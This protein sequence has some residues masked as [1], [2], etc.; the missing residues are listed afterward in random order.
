MSLCKIKGTGRSLPP[1]IFYADAAVVLFTDESGR[2]AAGCYIRYPRFAAISAHTPSL[3]G[4]PIVLGS[5]SGFTP[6]FFCAS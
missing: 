4:T 1:V 3:S 5:N 6:D 2:H